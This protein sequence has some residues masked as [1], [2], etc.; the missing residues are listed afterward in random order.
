MSSLIDSLQ[1]R[2]RSSTS[3]AAL[4]AV[5]GFVGLILGLTVGLIGDEVF[6]YGWFSLIFI[7]LV[8][9]G[10]LLRVTRSWSWPQILIFSFICVLIGLLLRMYILVAPG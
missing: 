5:K 4:W 8:V 10:L 1:D 2:A 3:A 6:Q 9:T 7:M